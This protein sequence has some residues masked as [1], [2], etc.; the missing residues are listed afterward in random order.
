M[1]IN[2]ISACNLS[3]QVY[4]PHRLS[5]IISQKYHTKDM[6]TLNFMR[7]LD[8]SQLMVYGLWFTV[9][10]FKAVTF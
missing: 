6:E 7:C 8:F 2:H 3:R 1:I 9:Y 4:Q 10:G 5:T